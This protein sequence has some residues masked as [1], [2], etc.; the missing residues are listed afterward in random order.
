L[1]I[2]HTRD[3]IRFFLETHFDDPDGDFKILGS[4]FE[5]H[6]EGE[7]AFVIGHAALGLSDDAGGLAR[8]LPLL[9]QDPAAAAAAGASTRAGSGH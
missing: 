3:T 4:F 1:V 6:I 2:Y 8:R 9:A 5:Y 7:R